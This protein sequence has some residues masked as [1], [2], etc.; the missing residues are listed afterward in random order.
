M[1]DERK[2]LWKDCFGEY[3][4]L[5]DVINPPKWF[6]YKEGLTLLK[7]V[8]CESYSDFKNADI[9]SRWYFYDGQQQYDCFI[10]NEG[11]GYRPFRKANPDLLDI[12]GTYWGSSKY[13]KKMSNKMDKMESVWDKNYMELPPK[14]QRGI[15]RFKDN[16]YGLEAQRQAFYEYN[17]KKVGWVGCKTHYSKFLKIKVDLYDNKLC[18]EPL[19]ISMEQMK[20]LMELAPFTDGW[21]EFAIP[22]ENGKQ[23]LKWI[24]KADLPSRAYKITKRKAKKLREKKAILKTLEKGE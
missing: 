14:E 8:E 9:R 3:Q 1:S 19:W 21:S 16:P 20:E 15:D 10:L 11:Y 17:M 24:D 4:T 12:H 23:G 6:N 18:A 5:E 2:Y 7:E 13:L 22:S